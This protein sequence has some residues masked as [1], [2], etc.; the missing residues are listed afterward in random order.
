M[1]GHPRCKMGSPDLHEFAAARTQ[2][3]F[4]RRSNVLCSLTVCIRLANARCRCFTA[5]R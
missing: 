3:L 4:A 2:N 1:W 5:S